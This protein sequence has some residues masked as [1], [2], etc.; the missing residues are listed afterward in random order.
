MSQ[1]PTTAQSFPGIEQLA[2]AVGLFN[3]GDFAGAL[4]VARQLEWTQPDNPAIVHFV[5]TCLTWHGEVDE[6]REYLERARKVN[7]GNPK[8]GADLAH[9]YVLHSRFDDAFKSLDDALRVAPFHPPTLRAKA[10]LLQR[11][12]RV[13][14]AATLL[15]PALAKEPGHPEVILAFA[16]IAG[17]INQ[18]EEAERRLRALAVNTAVPAAYRA[19]ANFELAA[20]QD[21]TERYDEAFESARQGNLHT[22]GRWDPATLSNWISGIIAAFSKE[23]LAAPPRADNPSELPVFI[24]GFPRSGTTLVEQILASHPQV[25]GA[26]ELAII[27]RLSRQ[28][29]PDQLTE[30]TLRSMAE[31]CL[32]ELKRRPGNNAAKS[33]VT[34]KNP[35]NY[36]HLGLLALMFKRPR[37]IHCRRDPI[38]TCLSCYFQDFAH[39]HPYTRDLAHLG[40]AY[41]DY[42]RVMDHYRNSLPFEMLEVDYETLVSDQEAQSRRLVEFAGLPW[43]DACLRPHETR[44]P[45]MTASG[46][47][48]QRPVYTT[49][50]QKWK[51]YE[52]HLGPLVETLR[53]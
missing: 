36:M 2:R 8:I 3:A 24:V 7:P 53:G 35:G 17:R 45:A 34:D 11:L 5:G 42:R 33:R 27:P 10:D 37:I 6:G 20:L 44:R 28:Y 30:A 32:A 41:N 46:A 1:V 40:I 14:E 13:D 12:G 52:A 23:R 21:A 39:R 48:V 31:Q 43:H 18:R 9:G 25:F 26:G 29:S 50:V 19:S 4:E 16:A 47:Q 22:P 49:S 51:R 38:D 15:S